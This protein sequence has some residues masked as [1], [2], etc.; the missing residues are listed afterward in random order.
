MVI[1]AFE[2]YHQSPSP[3]NYSEDATGLSRGV[4]TFVLLDLSLKL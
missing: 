2:T 3:T 4:F 1:I